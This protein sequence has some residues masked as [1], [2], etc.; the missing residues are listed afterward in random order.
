MPNAGFFRMDSAISNTG[1][2]FIDEPKEQDTLLQDTPSLSAFINPI[3][4]EGDVNE[5][6]IKVNAQDGSDED[7]ELLF[8]DSEQEDN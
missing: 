2:S 1:P 6:S 3:P 7:H 8:G 5:S 4:E